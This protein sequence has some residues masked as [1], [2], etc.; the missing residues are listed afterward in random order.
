MED[1]EIEEYNDSL[2]LFAGIALPGVMGRMSIFATPD[3]VAKEAFDIA[4]AMIVEFK[5]REKCTQQ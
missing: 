5:K 4:E 3:M 1:P 2:R